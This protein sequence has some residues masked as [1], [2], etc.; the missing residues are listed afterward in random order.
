MDKI[1]TILILILEQIVGLLFIVIVAVTLAQ[2]FCRYALGFSL[3]WSHELV[4][5]LLIWTVWLCIP[6]GLDRME[7]ISVTFL[8]DHVSHTSRARLAWFHWVLSIFFFGMVFFLSFPVAKAFEGMELFSIPIPTNARYY[9]ATAGSLLAVFVLAA[10]LF[11]PRK[12]T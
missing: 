9:A 3:T 1:K 8:V 2:V 4:I 5:L 11:K 7:H 10:K 12:G 6:I